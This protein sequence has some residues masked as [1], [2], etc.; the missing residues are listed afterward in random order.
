MFFNELEDRGTVLERSDAR[1]PAL[2]SRIGIDE[3]Y[4]KTH[5]IAGDDA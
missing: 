2:H 3:A 5:A 4:F 1:H